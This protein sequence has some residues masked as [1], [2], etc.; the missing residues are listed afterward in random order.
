MGGS[1][2]LAWLKLWK[3]SL[4]AEPISGHPPARRWVGMLSL[5]MAGSRIHLY[6]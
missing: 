5:R 3:Y 4:G 2:G 6:M 1:H